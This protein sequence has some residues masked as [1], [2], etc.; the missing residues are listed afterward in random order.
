MFAMHITGHYRGIYLRHSPTVSCPTRL[1]TWS[2]YL[3]SMWSPV[4]SSRHFRSANS[5]C[6]FKHYLHVLPKLVSTHFLVYNS[7]YEGIS[8]SSSCKINWQS[9]A[10]FIW[11]YFAKKHNRYHWILKIMILLLLYIDGGCLTSRNLT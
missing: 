5:K 10:V 3:H 8:Q 1:V 2:R 6:Y 4:W 9:I 7:T 11:T